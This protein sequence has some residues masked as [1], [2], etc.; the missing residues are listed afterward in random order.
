MV[1][2]L[3]SKIAGSYA[4]RGVASPCKQYLKK[5]IANYQYDHQTREIKKWDFCQIEWKAWQSA[6][7]FV[8]VINGFRSCG[9]FPYNPEWPEEHMHLF[10]VSEPMWRIDVAEAQVEKELANPELDES[11][12]AEAKKRQAGLAAMRQE[13]RQEGWHCKGSQDLQPQ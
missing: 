10:Q 5:E 9:I 4:R 6:A 3:A 8:N 12:L 11:A 13:E 1:T 7:S 2:Q